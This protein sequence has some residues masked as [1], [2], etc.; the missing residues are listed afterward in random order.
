[1]LILKNERFVNFSYQ[2]TTNPLY[3]SIIY[4]DSEE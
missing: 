2:N 1:M 3:T 4:I